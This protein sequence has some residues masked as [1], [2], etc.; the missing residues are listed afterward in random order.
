MFGVPYT[1]EQV[2]NAGAEVKGK[3]EMDAVIAYLQSLG[4]AMK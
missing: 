4:H 1:E 3:T 2:A